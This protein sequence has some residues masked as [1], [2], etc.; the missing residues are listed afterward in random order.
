VKRGAFHA[1][2]LTLAL[3]IGCRE[4]TQVTLVITTD[5]S[6]EALGDSSAPNP[7]HTSITAGGA[8]ALMT[9]RCVPGPNGATI[10]SVVLAP[11]GDR[12]APLVVEIATGVGVDPSTCANAPEACIVSRRALHYI[13]HTPLV[14]PVEMLGSC[15]GKTCDTCKTCVAGACIPDT[16]GDPSNCTGASGCDLDGGAQD[17]SIPTQRAITMLSVG[18]DHACVLLA[19]GDI[20]CWGNNAYGKLGDGTT[21]ASS[22]PVLVSSTYSNGST[23]VDVSAADNH[24]CGT[25]SNGYIVCWGDNSRGQLGTTNIGVAIVA[26]PDPSMKFTHVSAGRLHTCGLAGTQVYCWGDNEFGQL[27]HGLG[28]MTPT[29]TAVPLGKPATQVSAG[30]TTSCAILSG[31]SLACWETTLLARSATELASTARHPFK[32]RPAS[33]K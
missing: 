15:L 7:I 28:P 9:S 6:C 20:K 31:G 17:A 16:I 27:G 25:L 26:P 2:V 3:A 10:G 12:D 30:T 11:S 21:N 13:A 14:L 1:W 5:L 32:R 24:T 22:R 23:F 19:T 18:F 4:P 8:S 29:P 33:T